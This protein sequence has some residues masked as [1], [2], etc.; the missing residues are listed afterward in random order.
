M[1]QRE[2]IRKALKTL[3]TTKDSIVH[4]LAFM[5]KMPEAMD[6]EAD[7][8]YYWGVLYKIEERINMLKWIL[9]EED[10]L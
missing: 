6:G 9:G 1:K 3:Q 4:I 8:D 2:E 5:H 10:I 7:E